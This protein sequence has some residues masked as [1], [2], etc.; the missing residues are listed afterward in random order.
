[1]VLRT[2]GKKK[3][4]LCPCPLLFLQFFP[5]SLSLSRTTPDTGLAGNFR[6][7]YS[8]VCPCGCLRDEWVGLLQTVSATCCA[9]EKMA[10]PDLRMCLTYFSWGLQTLATV[11]SNFHT[12]STSTLLMKSW[13]R[14]VKKGI[15]S[16]RWW[17]IF[18]S[19]DVHS[20]KYQQMRIHHVAA[21]ITLSCMW[22]TKEKNKGKGSEQSQLL[23]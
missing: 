17:H 16:A 2:Y 20:T 14:K 23:G 13:S 22:L 18:H 12:L 3:V 11:R 9:L 1:M 21:M 7:L 6:W 8:I 5:S 4:D 10:F 19:R 15:L